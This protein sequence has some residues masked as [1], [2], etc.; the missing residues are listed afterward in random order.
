[1]TRREYLDIKILFRCFRQKNDASK[2]VSLFKKAG[3]QYV[4]L[5]AENHDG[6]AMYSLECKQDVQQNMQVFR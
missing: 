5:V 1:M 3:I 6:F 4:M 2:W